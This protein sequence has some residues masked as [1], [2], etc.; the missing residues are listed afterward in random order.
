L[1]DELVIEFKNKQKELKEIEEQE[2]LKKEILSQ[3]KESINE[4]ENICATFPNIENEYLSG[5]RSIEKKIRS[6]SLINDIY[7]DYN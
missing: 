6:I 5:V 7:Y 4:L 3:S 1:S 2:N